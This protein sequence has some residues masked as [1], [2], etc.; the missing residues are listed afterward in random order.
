MDYENMTDSSLFEALRVKISAGD[1]EV[2][3]HEQPPE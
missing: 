2:D 3:H 1:F